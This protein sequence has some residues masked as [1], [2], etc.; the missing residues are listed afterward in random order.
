MALFG[1]DNGDA[2]KDKSDDKLDDKT[3]VKKD[4]QA[5][6]K[7]EGEKDGDTEEKDDDKPESAETV[8]AAEPEE[9][10]MHFDDTPIKKKEVSSA[11]TSPTKSVKE[12]VAMF[13]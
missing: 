4:D 5:E 3:D 11:S 7:K 12:R 10:E 9:I 1:D 2:D 6:E 8:K 13:Q